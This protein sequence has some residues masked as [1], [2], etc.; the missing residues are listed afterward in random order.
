MQARTQN[1][2]ATQA[3]GR[4]FAIE[5]VKRMEQR[6][7][8]CLDSDGPGC[9]YAAESFTS[10]QDEEAPTREGPQSDLVLRAYDELASR[11]T[12]E[13][14]L[15]FFVILTDYLGST[16]AGAPPSKDY[17]ER[18]EREGRFD[19]WGA[20]RLPTAVHRAREDAGFQSLLAR[21]QGSRR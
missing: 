19:A 2:L 6:W 16:I 21:A 5:L 20:H 8:D 12:R 10:C 11:A 17:Y 4:R 18:A 13:A 7:T 1:F 3:D 14:V 15:G 9:D